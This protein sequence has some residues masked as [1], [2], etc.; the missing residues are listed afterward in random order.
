MRKVAGNVALVLV[1]LAA[2]LFGYLWWARL[3]E[4]P[5]ETAMTMR[6]LSEGIRALTKKSGLDIESLQRKVDGAKRERAE[7]LRILEQMTQGA[8]PQQAVA[9][10]KYMIR[11]G[12]LMERPSP[13]R[14]QYAERPKVED[15]P[16]DCGDPK[17]NQAI[18]QLY[19]GGLPLAERRTTRLF[20]EGLR[21]AAQKIGR[22]FTREEE[23]AVFDEVEEQRVDLFEALRGV[24]YVRAETCVEF[25]RM[26]R[27]YPW[28][29]TETGWRG[30]DIPDDSYHADSIMTEDGMLSF[31]ASS[32]SY[33]EFA[34]PKEFIGEERERL[35]DA[36]EEVASA[37]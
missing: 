19:C 14:R 15:N 32:D 30:P 36:I 2:G 13:W 9:S 27:Y 3:Y 26:G 22:T 5:P 11:K 25:A 37:L 17:L 10:G 1:G 23:Q 7:V 34:P 18:F 4:G 16:F 21:R 20:E 28:K 24:Y 35:F 12:R 29:K 6:E 33:P 31:M 8:T